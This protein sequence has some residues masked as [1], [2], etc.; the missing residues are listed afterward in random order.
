MKLKIVGILIYLWVLQA[1]NTKPT[2]MKIT[3]TWQLVSGITITGGKL[4]RT[5]Y[6][7]GQEMIKIRNDS[8]FAF[9]K[10]DLHPEK[11]SSTHF[12]AGGGTYTLQG[13]TYTEYL[14]YYSDRNWEGRTFKF[15]L[16]LHKDTLIQTGLEK[17]EKEGVDR[18]IIEKYIRLNPRTKP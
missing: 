13:N 15:T 4:V 12:D 5:D 10:H 11:D 17:V 1:C 8:H 9:L 3:G 6:K 2:G 16:T 18:T 14:D 7:K